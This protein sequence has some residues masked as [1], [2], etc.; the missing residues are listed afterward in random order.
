MSDMP[1][2]EAYGRGLADYV[3]V[4]QKIVVLDADSIYT[5]H[6]N[7]LYIKFG[8]LPTLTDFEDKG[9]LPNI[10]QAV[11]IPNTQAGTYYVMVRSTYGEGSYTIVAHTASSFP[12]LT[13]GTPMTGSLQGTFDIK[14]YQVSVIAGV[15][16]SVDLDGANTNNDYS[17]YVDLEYA[18]GTP[19]WGQTAPF[20]VGTHGWQR[21]Q[22]LIVPAKP[23]RSASIHALFRNH[24]GTAWFDD[25]RI[26]ASPA[27]A[28]HR[29]GGAG[30][31]VSRQ[32]SWLRTAIL[33]VRPFGRT[34]D[35]RCRSD[36]SGVTASEIARRDC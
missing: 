26:E 8:A 10:D 15:R 32:E 20:A 17:L 9:D 24:T 34:E 7:E 27:S 33:A 2:R 18:D 36:G 21:R 19:L 4:N 5:T 31:S 30:E 14:Y 25:F 12:S 29:R 28:E 16:L 22:V 3:D 23:V 11:E 6:V 1:Q 35:R 13:V